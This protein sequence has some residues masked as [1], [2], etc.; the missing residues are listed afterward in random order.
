VP[1][2]VALLRGINVGGAHKVPMSDLRTLFETLGHADVRTYIQSGNVVFTAKAGTPAR[3][4]AAL[5]KS[6]AGEFGFDV[7]VLLRTAPE[8][9]ATMKRNPYGEDAYVTFL[10]EPADATKVKAIDPAPFAPD[11]FAVHGREVFVTCPNGYGRTKINNT[12]FERKLATKA[13]TR[14]WRTVTTLYDWTKP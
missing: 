2:Y 14:N 6:V 12:F 13:T 9:A 11:E 7:T 1:T 10:E 3:V 4:R 5:E 8:L